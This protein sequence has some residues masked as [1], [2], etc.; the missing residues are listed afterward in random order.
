MELICV[1]VDIV[2]DLLDYFPDINNLWRLLWIRPIVVGVRVL[3]VEA[4]GVISWWNVLFLLVFKSLVSV[5][6]QL[7]QLSNLLI[8]V[9]GVFL[10]SI[11]VI[12]SG[13]GSEY[14]MNEQLPELTKKHKLFQ[15]PVSW[16][17]FS[18]YVSGPRSPSCSNCPTT[19]NN[20]QCQC[21]YGRLPKVR[22]IFWQFYCH[23]N[24]GRFMGR[25]S[26]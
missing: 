5:G 3:A 9:L 8:T 2:T 17:I 20:T 21:Y 16:G 13:R 23:S 19:I 12:G 14:T 24:D 25:K 22:F 11:M 26:T 18:I 6:Y 7:Q 15:N 10:Q 4:S 1:F